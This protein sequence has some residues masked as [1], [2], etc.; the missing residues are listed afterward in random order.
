MQLPDSI[1]RAI[2]TFIQAFAG[3]VVLQGV[4]LAADANDGN[5][6]T[7]L[8][9]RVA[10]TAVVAGFI[11]LFTFIQNWAEDNTAL[12]AVLKATPSAGQNPVTVDP[13]K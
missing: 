1:R 5:L 7:S 11:A 12:P 10:V 6:D 9:K 8:W 3:V 13:V 4:A 2:R